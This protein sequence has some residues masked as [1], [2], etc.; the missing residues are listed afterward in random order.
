M[1]G[2]V[3]ELVPARRLDDGLTEVAGGPALVM[4][5]AA[6]DVLRVEDSRR[7]EI[8]RRGMG[9]SSSTW[10]GATSAADSNGES[11]SGHHRLPPTHDDH[12]PTPA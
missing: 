9:D 11:N 8:P 7:F 5:C 12:R 1:G 3:R 6:R 2:L 10:S 4:G